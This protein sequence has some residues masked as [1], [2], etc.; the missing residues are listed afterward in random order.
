MHI[1]IEKWTYVLLISLY[2]SVLD[3]KAASDQLSGLS[4]QAV[5]AGQGHSVK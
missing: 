4:N 1:F 5:V 3:K 2:I